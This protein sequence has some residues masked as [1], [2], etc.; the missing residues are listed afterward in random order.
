MAVDVAS[1]PVSTADASSTDVWKDRIRDARE[2]QR[3][4]VPTWLL[5][6]AFAAGQHWVAYDK[7]NH[8]VRS[9]RDLE[10]SR[11]AD[12]ELYTADR[13]TE[14]RMA[15]LGELESDD[16]RP[17]LLVVQ[18]GE[19]A[20]AA[21]EQ[22]N[23]AVAHAWEHEWKAQLALSQARLYTLDL[24]VSALRCRWDPSKGPVTVHVPINPAGE[25]VLHP[26]ELASLEQTGAFTDGSLPR[27]QP[28]NEGYTCWEAYS[29]FGILA[30]PGCNHEDKFPWEILFRPVSI[31]DLIDEY[32]AA[33]AG[34]QED[35]DIASAMGLSTDQ[36]VQD[37]RS[38][39][40][41][42]RRLKGHVWVYTCFQR[43]NSR[44]PKGAVAVIASNNYKL[45]S[46]TDQ[47][48]Y[49]RPNGEY[50]AGVVYLHWWRLNDRFY[51]RAFTEPLRD[52]Q[53]IINR[54]KTQ[55]TEIIDRGMPG[56]F[57]R[58]GDVPELP[59]GAPGEVTFLAKTAEPP[60][61]KPGLDPG[62]W[63][64]QD[65]AEL[66]DDLAHAST[67]SALRLGENPQGVETYS[68][69]A[70][71]NDNETSK[72]VTI[73]HDHHRQIG[74]LTELG[75]HDIR[76]YWPATKQILV[77]G[78]D[79]KIAAAAFQKSIIP[80]FFMVSAATGAP[81]PR[82]QGAQ[83]KMLDAIWA[84]AVQAWVAVNDGATWVAWYAAC[85]KAGKVLDLPGA[86][87]DTQRELAYLENESIER[88]ELP[89][90]ADYDSITVHLP[91]HRE[92][93]DQARAAGDQQTLLLLTRHIAD[94]QEVAQ[95]NAANVTA[96]A[97]AAAASAGLPSPGQPGSATPAGTNGN[98]NP[99]GAVDYM[100]P[101]ARVPAPNRVG[102]EFGS[103]AGGMGGQ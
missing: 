41:G 33:A 20:E 58:E 91:I 75:V 62:S 72:R 60:V 36:A 73:L 3:P 4:N 85:L 22:L 49:Q 89:N 18:E 83:L 61:I 93:Q 86:K 47:L 37:A 32:G 25:P 51:S 9:L 90:V 12:R 14:Y 59:T 88:G 69:L 6:L 21:A 82:S 1:N 23:D 5:N 19:Q 78:E 48:P 76:R 10:P 38:Q 29:A 79:N 50:H 53:R 13:I 57:A 46:F 8:R 97:Q 84:A 87:A 16:D 70:Q 74:T 98:Q 11:Y 71:L 96:T 54:R 28:V 95:Q 102:V 44:Y 81:A 43:P 17:E 7:V 94:H 92:A 30:P 103:L 40:A 99:A 35:P 63:M 27:Y 24:G 26:D 15:Q 67:L 66:A 34:L 45:L 64:S 101:M 39:G 31:D 52:P 65:I 42:M 56:W 100:Q 2:A 55:K 68:Q 80:D 77:S